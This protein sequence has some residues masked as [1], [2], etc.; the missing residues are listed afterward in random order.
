VTVPGVPALVATNLRRHP[1]CAAHRETKTMP[2]NPNEIARH[3]V[4]PDDASPLAVAAPDALRCATCNRTFPFLAPNLIE[5]LPSKPLQ[6]PAAGVSREYAA[7]YLH[8][9]PPAHEFSIDENKNQRESE[10]ENENLS[11][12]TPFNAPETSSPALVQLRERQAAELLQNFQI[13]AN[14]AAIDRAPSAIANKKNSSVVFCDLSAASG[15]TTFAAARHA[16][17]VF[18]CDLSLAAVRYASAKASRLGL[19][20]F[21]VIRADYLQAPFRNSIDQLTCIDTLIRGSWHESQL[22]DAI[23]RSLSPRGVAVIDFHNWWHNPLRRLG[24]LPQN[25]GQNRSYSR[26]E[27]LDLLARANITDFKISPYI[28][29]ARPDTFIGK[30]IRAMIP[31]ARFVI[32][33]SPGGTRDPK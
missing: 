31:A 20:N 11:A 15:Y 16:H 25:F 2:L 7:A 13:A 1:I 21:V 33:F 29:E 6:L 24:L 4:C 8:S 12:P 9:F 17:I 32:R 27:V 26:R 28:P 3:L 14:E 5:L 19:E 18:R 30:I 23:S 22:L 10:N